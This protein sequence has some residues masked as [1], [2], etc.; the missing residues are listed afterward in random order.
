M[1]KIIECA[2]ENMDDSEIREEWMIIQHDQYGMTPYAEAI[3]KEYDKRKL[4]E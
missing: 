1:D 4:D 2:V 3:G